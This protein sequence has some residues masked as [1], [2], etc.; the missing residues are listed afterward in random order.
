M[1]IKLLLIL[2]AIFV[3]GFSCEDGEP[4]GHIGVV[5]EGESHYYPLNPGQ[6]DQSEYDKPLSEQI[7]YTI[8]PPNMHGKLK[9]HH[10]EL[11]IRLDECRRGKNGL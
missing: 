11:H 9:A 8:F 6:D 2:S 7:G 4:E 10:D 5:L 3:L 1:H